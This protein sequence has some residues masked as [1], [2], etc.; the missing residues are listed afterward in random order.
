MATADAIRRCADCGKTFT[1]HHSLV[2]PHDPRPTPPAT[3]AE[4]PECVRR[5]VDAV[6][7][8]IQQEGMAAIRE[9]IDARDA[10]RD[11]YAKKGGQ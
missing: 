3:P 11:H 1:G 6:S 9:A 10:V 4:M 7:P 8:L 2:C 5:L